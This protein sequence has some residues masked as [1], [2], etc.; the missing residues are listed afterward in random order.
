MNGGA[1]PY[2]QTNA[3]FGDSFTT[4][5]TRGPPFVWNNSTATFNIDFTG[6]NSI[7]SSD[8][9]ANSGAFVPNQQTYYV[10]PHGDFDWLL[11]LGASGQ[12]LPGSSFDIDLPHTRTLSHAGSD[13]GF[14]MSDSGT[15]ALLGLGLVIL[16]LLRRRKAV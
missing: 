16:G 13:G 6:L 8:G 14:T 9:F 15:L 11:L 4:T 12:E 2:M 10:N 1:Y 5:D 3:I 7:S